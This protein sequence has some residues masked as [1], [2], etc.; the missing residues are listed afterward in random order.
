MTVSVSDSRSGDRW[1]LPLA[2]AWIVIVLAAFVVQ[3]LPN[4]PAVSRIDVLAL[5]LDDLLGTGDAPPSAVPS[6]WTFL[7]QRFPLAA[8]GALLLTAAWCLG[9]AMLRGIARR[10]PLT[11]CESFVLQYGLG[12][13][14]LSLVTLAAG[15]A[16]RLDTPV[17][18]LPS[19]VALIGLLVD[20]GSRKHASPP[21]DPEPRNR[22]HGQRRRVAGESAG[23]PAAAAAR[24]VRWPRPLDVVFGLTIAGTVVWLLLGSLSPPTDFDVREYH[25]QGPK[26]WFQSGAL[27]FLPHNVYTSFPFLSEMI[28][29]AGMVI[30]GD[31]WIGALVGKFALASFAPMTA[32]CVYCVTRRIAGRR[33]GLLAALIHITTPWT[34]R[35]SIIAYAEGALSFYTAATG[36]ALLLSLN[37]DGALQ[38]RRLSLLT[39][40]VAGSALA[41]K[42]T[43][44]VTAVLPAFA[45]LG[46]LLAVPPDR[47]LPLRTRVRLRSATSGLSLF[48]FGVSLAAGPWLIRNVVDTGNPVYPLAWSVFGGRHWDAD[49][50]A[51]WQDAH[52]PD[53]HSLIRIPQHVLDIAVRND[54]TNPL[55]WA[56][57]VPAVLWCGNRRGFALVAL[58]AIWKLVAW[59]AFTHRIDR[60]WVP[61]IPL[62][63]V[64]AG[65]SRNVSSS[66]VWRTGLLTAVALVTAFN[67]RFVTLPLVGYHAGL[68]DLNAARS[69]VIRSDLRYLNETLPNDATVLMVGEAEVFDCEFPVIYNTVFDDCVFE[70]LT[71]DPADAAS[72]PRHRRMQPA[73]Q[74]R[75]SL[76]RRGVT[77]VLVNWAEILRYRRPDSYGYAEYIQPSRLQR[78]VTTGVL[79]PAR[80]LLSR[81]WSDMTEEDRAIVRSWDASESLIADDLFRSVQFFSVRT[82]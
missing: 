66:P 76:R 38:R 65:C 6:G 28:S 74:I 20:R 43:G 21:E 3:D 69:V 19:L 29:L 64:I 5:L 2:A 54:W 59:W 10:V 60:F 52:S 31:W 4:N 61:A 75:Q 50:N 39:G 13:A 36:L 68:Q 34:T 16:G 7:R 18:L 12:M 71:A 9:A 77:H 23:T 30:A 33:A 46:L 63:A 81:P 62:V 78:L 47:S 14:A 58:L 79:E 56:L 73:E 35:I 53:E 80:T 57:A 55:L 82:D 1:R 45:G 41:C 40:L 11:R 27:H 17:I 44:L 70:Q 72:D 24:A 37:T 15:H 42:Y 48:L 51:R 49:V 26:E 8:Q 22:Q 32:L 67:L 25:L